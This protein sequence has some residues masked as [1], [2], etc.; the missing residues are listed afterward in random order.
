MAYP[1]EKKLVVAVSSSAVFDMAAADAVFRKDGEDAY[2]KYQLDHLDEAFAKGVAFPFVKRLLGINKRYAEEQPV[3]VIVL[4]RNDPDSG[5]RFFRSCQHYG[6]GITRGAFLTGKSPFPYIPAFNASLFLS[7]HDDDV[8][9]AIAAGM[10][11]GLVLPTTASDDETDTEL[12]VAFDFD[13]VL[14]DDEAETVFHETQDVKEFQRTELSKAATPHNPGP[15]KDLI[16]KLSFFQ[17]LEAGVQKLWNY[18][19]I[20]RDDGLSYGDY[21]EQLTFLL[22]LKMADEQSKPPFNKPSPI[23][24]GKDWPIRCCKGRRRSG[25][26]LPPHAGGTRQA[27]GHARRHLPQ[28]AEQDPGPG[29][30][31]PADRGPDRQGAVV[32]PDADV[33]GDAYEGLLQK[34]AEDVKGG[35]GQYF[36]P[37]PLIAAMVD[38]RRPAAR[39][40][41]LRSGLRHRRLPAG[42]A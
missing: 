38:V 7:A 25:D 29:Q 27:H 6:L 26:A 37:R 3:E 13:G 30:A 20:L 28:G 16:T 35:A 8:R 36:T 21:V 22:F 9:N 32:E 42:R 19:N 17:K 2:R 41:H 18:C 40:N 12:R 34:N 33:K 23:P 11:A 14:A 1:I 31:A 24:K 15:L 4:S 39:R 5:R 10:P